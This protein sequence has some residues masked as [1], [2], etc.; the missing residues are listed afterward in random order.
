MGEY[1]SHLLPELTHEVGPTSRVYRGANVIG[2]H[3]VGAPDIGYRAYDLRT[4]C[5]V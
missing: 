5:R 1:V 4:G 2:K 3:I